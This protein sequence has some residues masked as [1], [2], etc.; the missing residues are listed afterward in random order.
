MNDF[1]KNT[2][3][4]NMIKLVT[5]PFAFIPYYVF[6]GMYEGKPASEII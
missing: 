3:R 1:L 4:S 6:S 5:S 2:N